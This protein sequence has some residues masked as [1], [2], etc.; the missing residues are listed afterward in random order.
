M[1]KPAAY[2]AGGVFGSVASAH[3]SK[4]IGAGRAEVEEVVVR[5]EKPAREYG[6]GFECGS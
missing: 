3:H 6:V 2:R 1:V 4:G 5:E